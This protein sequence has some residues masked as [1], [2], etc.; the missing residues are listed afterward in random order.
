VQRAQTLL[1]LV[2]RVVLVS[3]ARTTLWAVVKTQQS[4]TSEHKPAALAVAL[5]EYS[6]CTHIEH[7]QCAWTPGTAVSRLLH[8]L[9][10]CCCVAARTLHPCYSQNKLAA[11]KSVQQACVESQHDLCRACAWTPPAA[12][13]PWI[14]P[15]L[16]GCCKNPVITLPDQARSKQEPSAIAAAAMCEIYIEGRAGA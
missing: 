16:V 14:A 2:C 12:M 4:Q 9:S 6:T 15:E 10:V 8:T 13:S 1:H 7:A 11:T 5:R 3:S